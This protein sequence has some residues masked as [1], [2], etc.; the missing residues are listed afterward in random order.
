MAEENEALRKQLKNAG[1]EPIALKNTAEIPPQPSPVST[2]AGQEKETTQSSQDKKVVTEMKSSGLKK[3]AIVTSEVEKDVLRKV[4]KEGR[5]V[6]QAVSSKG[7]ETNVKS[8]E[9]TAVK[10]SIKDDASMKEDAGEDFALNGRKVS[11]G[12]SDTKNVKGKEQITTDVTMSQITKIHSD[13]LVNKS[14]DWLSEDI[15]NQLG[16]Q[17]QFLQQTN[18]RLGLLREEAERE[19]RELYIKNNMLASKILGLE[20]IFMGKQSN[21]KWDLEPPRESTESPVKIPERA[22][23]AGLPTL[24]RANSTSSTNSFNKNE[25]TFSALPPSA[26][27]SATVYHRRSD[28]STKRQST[29]GKLPHINVSIKDKVDNFRKRNSIR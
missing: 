12:V 2:G 28:S 16:T 10:D 7:S 5:A 20:Q 27:L 29:K 17:I 26:P 11:N 23:L 25:F 9:E 24:N 14:T 1:I 19:C 8:K 22:K 4:D 15:V 13:A 21:A 18:R 6:N 3:A